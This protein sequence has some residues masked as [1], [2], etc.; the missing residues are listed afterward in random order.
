MPLTLSDRGRSP[1][2]KQKL[3]QF[4]RRSVWCYG[5]GSCPQLPSCVGFWF[6]I[7]Q[8]QGL[9][10]GVFPRARPQGVGVG[11][12]GTAWQTAP[13]G[14]SSRSRRSP[15]LSFFSRLINLNFFD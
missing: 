14:R 8:G 4:S 2:I 3:T 13:R 9:Q 15:L 7:C 5:P 11:E 1:Q 6:L 10:V 12:P